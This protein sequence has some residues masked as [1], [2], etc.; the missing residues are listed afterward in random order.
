MQRGRQNCLGRSGEP[1]NRLSALLT[2]AEFHRAL[3]LFSEK[4]PDVEV[5]VIYGNHEERYGFPRAE[6]ADMIFGTGT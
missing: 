5:S 1:E 6:Q 3:V 2:G 4:H